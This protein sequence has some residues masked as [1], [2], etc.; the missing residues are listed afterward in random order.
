MTPLFPSS[1]IR[2]LILASIA[3]ISF[4]AIDSVLAAT[5]RRE[6]ASAAAQLNSDGQRLM[7]QGKYEQAADA[8]RSAIANQRESTQY[9]LALGQALMYSGQLDAAASTLTELLKSSPMSGPANLQMARVL[10]EQTQFEEAAFY[11]HRAIYGQWKTNVSGNRLNAR[12][13]LAYFL[14]ERGWKTDLMAELLALQ[15]QAPKD[16]ATRR[17]LAD[18]F[19]AAD[20]PAQSRTQPTPR[21]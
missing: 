1:P 12:F 6:T 4:I 16:P 19:A 14:S 3:C 21:P 5:E 8:F 20:A 17:K 11:Y 2:T 9:P 15:Q 7:Q 13:E 18:L 10:A